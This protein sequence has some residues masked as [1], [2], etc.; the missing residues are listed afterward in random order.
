MAACHCEHGVA[1][2]VHHISYVHLPKHAFGE[3]LHK[4]SF[5]PQI[6]IALEAVLLKLHAKPASGWTLIRVNFDFTQENGPKV[7]DGC[8]FVSGHCFTKL[9]YIQYITTLS[10]LV[11]NQGMCTHQLSFC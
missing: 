3:V 11:C 1:R 2:G 9:Q 7:S 6:C 8:S 5:L 10:I 4:L